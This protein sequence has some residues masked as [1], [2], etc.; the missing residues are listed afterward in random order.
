[1][2]G[3]KAGAAPQ[4]RPGENEQGLF[5]SW[6]RLS[7]HLPRV[8]PSWHFT[9]PYRCPVWERSGVGVPRTPLCSP[10]VGKLSVPGCAQKT[11]NEIVMCGGLVSPCFF[12]CALIAN[13]IEVVEIVVE[14]RCECLFFTCK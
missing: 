1:M 3:T 9:H 5:S 14:A 7:E 13:A 8:L 12:V 6:A 10:A 4:N 2:P 11:N